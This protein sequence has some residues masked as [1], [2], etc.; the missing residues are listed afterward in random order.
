MLVRMSSA[1]KI[2]ETELED[3]CSN[4]PLLDVAKTFTLVSP[5]LSVPGVSPEVLQRVLSQA[6]KVNV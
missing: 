4:M 6:N 5:D 2:K 3:L 1:L